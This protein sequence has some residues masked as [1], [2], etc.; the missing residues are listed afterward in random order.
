MDNDDDLDAAFVSIMM[1]ATTLLNLYADLSECCM[2]YEMQIQSVGEFV[3]AYYWPTGAAFQDR[4]LL[5]RSL[6]IL[7]LSHLMT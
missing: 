4:H 7:R 5:M 6:P 2:A 1:S 3:W